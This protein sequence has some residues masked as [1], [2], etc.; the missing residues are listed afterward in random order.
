MPQVV[1]PLGG[2][3]DPELA[4][5]FH[6]SCDLGGWVRSLDARLDWTRVAP[7]GLAHLATLSERLRQVR[8]L[9]V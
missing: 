6:V 1:C 3:R 9:G 5:A 4:S 7:S 2:R 8:G